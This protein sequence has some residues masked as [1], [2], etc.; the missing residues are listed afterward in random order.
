ML[1]CRKKRHLYQQ[2][3]KILQ[4]VI[5]G[6]MEIIMNPGDMKILICDDS[7]MVQKKMKTLLQGNGFTQ[8]FEAKDGEAAVEAYKNI[9]PDVVFMDIVMPGKSG[10][11]AL[12]EIRAMDPQ[13]KVIMAS[14]IGTQSNLKEAIDKGAY[15]FLQKPIEDAQVLKLLG[16]ITGQK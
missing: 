15:D 4:A 10:V 16:R 6:G 7:I 2:K 1:Y 5:G 8:I 12:A 11:E 9:Q 14:S 3:G 13:A